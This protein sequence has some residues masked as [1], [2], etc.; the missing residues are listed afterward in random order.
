MAQPANPSGPRPYSG[1]QSSGKHQA[2]VVNKPLSNGRRGHG[3]RVGTSLASTCQV[4][5]EEAQKGW[6]AVRAEEPA[7][8][9][10]HHPVQGKGP[11][12]SHVVIASPGRK[13]LCKWCTS[14]WGREG[15]PSHKSQAINNRCRERRGFVDQNPC[16]S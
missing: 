6:E 15:T 2:I 7:S 9:I 1:S 4:L 5:G 8:S 10:G 13:S 12:L 3:V 14:C 16:Q 11:L